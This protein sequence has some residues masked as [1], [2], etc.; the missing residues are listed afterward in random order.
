[1]FCSSSLPEEIDLCLCHES[2]RIFCPSCNILRLLFH[3]KVEPEEA[4]KKAILSIFSMYIQCTYMK[5][6][7]C[8]NSNFLCVEDNQL[9]QTHYFEL[10]PNLSIYWKQ[11][12]LF[13]VP[14]HG[15]FRPAFMSL[16]MLFLLYKN[17]SFHLYKFPNPF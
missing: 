17:P 9:F 4:L 13:S 11:A 7:M 12:S 3:R 1:M 2:E 8:V 5:N 14:I 6:G 10:L 16:L 15:I